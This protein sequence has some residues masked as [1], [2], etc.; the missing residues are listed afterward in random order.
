MENMTPLYGPEDIRALERKVKISRL[1]CW[2]LGLGALAA[3]VSCCALTN[4]GNAGRM[5]MML[6]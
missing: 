5:D 1:L 4:S 6:I 2:L 3:C